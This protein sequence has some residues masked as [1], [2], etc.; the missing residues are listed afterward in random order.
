MA[1]VGLLALTGCAGGSSS[2]STVTVTQTITETAG[3]PT[4]TSAASAAQEVKYG[5]PVEGDIVKFTVSDVRDVTDK[6]DSLDKGT[7]A[8]MIEVCATGDLGG[9]ISPMQHF[10]LLDDEGATYQ[11]SGSTGGRLP[12]PQLDPGSVSISTGQCRKG[13]LFFDAPAGAKITGA[14]AIDSSGSSMGTWGS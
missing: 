9:P 4:E 11:P 2:V 10:V 6:Q 12:T 13:N 1:T 8:A 7:W 5:K 14:E 3:A